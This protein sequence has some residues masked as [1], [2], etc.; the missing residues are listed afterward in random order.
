[1][2]KRKQK[3]EVQEEPTT[4]MT[5][6]DV[7][8]QLREKLGGEVIEGPDQPPQAPEQERTANLPDP[9]NLETADVGGSRMHLARSHRFQQMQIRFEEKP[10]EE[11]TALL[12]DEGWR[13]RG[14]ETGWTKQLDREARWRSQADAERLFREIAS[15]IRAEKGLEPLMEKSR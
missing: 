13:W 3:E 10:S 5:L 12:K 6:Q 2:A 8:D 4:A 11:V 15:N 1:M 7:T 14:Q 9:Y